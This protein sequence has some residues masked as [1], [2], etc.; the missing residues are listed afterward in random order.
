ME[1]K[2]IMSRP[3]VTVTRKTTVK[4]AVAKMAKKGVSCVVVVE[5]KLPIGIFTKHDLVAALDSGVN[6]AKTAIEI[7]M[8]TPV[9]PIE[10]SDDLFATARQMGRM[11]VRRFVIVDAHNL[12]SGI[13][14]ETDIVRTFATRAFPYDV[15][16]AALADKGLAASPATPLKKIVRM[17]AESRKSCVVIVKN[18]KPVGVIDEGLLVKLAAKGGNLLKSAA[19][20]K[21]AKKF[22]AAL[23]D[24]SVREAVINMTKANNREIVVA[25]SDGHH[26]GVV[27][28]RDLI[29]Y[30]EKTQ[31]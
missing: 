6:F 8:H 7:V 9:M 5:K 2:A 17:M 18:K 22:T 15:M 19:G 12:L 24:S 1:V 16:L 20:Q 28:Q 27:S 23:P 30:I 13:V 31:S 10:E 21:M 14:T 4:E 26:Y 25:D 11:D 3:A 29:R